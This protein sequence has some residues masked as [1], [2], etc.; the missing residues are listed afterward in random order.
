[1]ISDIEKLVEEFR[2]QLAA[3]SELPALEQVKASFIGKKGRITDILKNLRN[4]GPEEKS[5]TG[6][7]ANKA[8]QAM[9]ALLEAR[10][11]EIKTAY[12]ALRDD[13]KVDYA[14]RLNCLFE[15]IRAKVRE[16]RGDPG[17]TKGLGDQAI[18][19]WITPLFEEDKQS[20]GEI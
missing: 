14:A 7:A 20:T 6:Q 12:E 1:M 15:P 16:M 2:V 10:R 18:R 3:E 17:L 4:L 19:I 11:D 8:K 13:E 5:A 9:Q